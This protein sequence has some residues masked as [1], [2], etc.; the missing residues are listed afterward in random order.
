MTPV[1]AY[2]SLVSGRG[3]PSSARPLLSRAPIVPKESDWFCSCRQP[4]A[5]AAEA[6]RLG[7]NDTSR[8]PGTAHVMAHLAS[9][10]RI[11]ETAILESPFP[12][13]SRNVTG[14]TRDSPL[15]NVDLPGQDVET[16][17]YQQRLSC[18]GP[19][20]H[21]QGGS[22]WPRVLK[23]ARLKA[24]FLPS[25]AARRHCRHD[26]PLPEK[27][28]QDQQRTHLRWW[29][30]ALRETTLQSCVECRQGEPRRGRT[31]PRPPPAPARPG[32]RRATES[33]SDIPGAARSYCWRRGRER[34]SSLR[35][36]AHSGRC[37]VSAAGTRLVC[38]SL[39]CTA[40]ASGRHRR[41]VAAPAAT[42]HRWGRGDCSSAPDSA[43]DIA[44]RRGHSLPPNWLLVSVDR[45]AT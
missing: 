45:A 39:L 7:V 24:A 44:C 5:L 36:G 18:R 34:R 8:C 15:K 42:P 32:R 25:V 6:A 13:A 29:Q 3:G 4:R 19:L 33:S 22:V 17:S 20:Q 9:S 43:R 27:P 40:E 38:Y 23:T 26:S 35:G 37:S 12:A 14:K 1:A 28:L 2:P 41:P 21:M 31:E 16:S 30:H 10:R 11:W